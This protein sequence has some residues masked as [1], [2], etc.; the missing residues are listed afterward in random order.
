M[1]GDK[2][3]ALVTGGN[4]G[5]GY[6]LVKQLSLNGFQVIL[7]SRNLET[8]KEAVQKLK[9]IDLD[10]SC[11]EMNVTDRESITQA[12]VTLNEHFGRKTRIW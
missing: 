7:A 11:V 10:V 5:I 3:V 6:E 1:K 4:R 12:A 2:Q 9:E 8:G